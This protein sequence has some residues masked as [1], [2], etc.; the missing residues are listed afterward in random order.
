MIRK[1]H[2]FLKFSVI[3]HGCLSRRPSVLLPLFCSALFS[4]LLIGCGAPGEPS[5]RKA[6]TPVAVADLS[7]A[8]QGYTVVLNFTLP[9]E[10]VEHKSLKQLPAVEIYRSLQPASAALV[11]LAPGAAPAGQLLVTIPPEMVEHLAARGRL[12]YEDVLTAADFS[13]NPTGSLATYLV[14]TRTSPK[15]VSANSNTASLVVQ[16]A[17]DAISDLKAEVTREAIVLSWAPPQKTLIGPAPPI[18]TYAI[19]RAESDIAPA[20]ST[21]PT[22]AAATPAAPANSP[23]ASAEPQAPQFV[24]LGDVSAPPY[25]DTQIQFGKIYAYS[26]RSVVQYDQIRI[27]SADSN[28]ASVTRLDNFLPTPPEGLVV[29]LIPAQ[30]QSPAYLDLSWSISSDN[31]IAGYNIYRTDAKSEGAGAPRTKLNPALLLTPAFRDMNVTPGHHYL[32]SVTAVN[33]AGNESPESAAA[34][35]FAPDPTAPAESQP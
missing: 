3:R 22:A 2:L 13:Q 20:A 25:R 30:D 5:E 35:G 24:H 27:D 15:K 16:P 28:L 14:R 1:K 26:V 4:V 23:D 8:Q 21:S 29:A 6:P 32:Y 19:Y 9:K 17:A 18:V 11:V 10:S 34:A 7:A 31:D 12:R 33:R